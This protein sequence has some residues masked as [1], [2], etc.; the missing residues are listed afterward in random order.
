LPDSLVLQLFVLTEAR[1]AKYGGL[2]LIS[3]ISNL[4]RKCRWDSSENSQLE[5]REHPTEDYYDYG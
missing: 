1:E 3:I 4:K 2:L 5:N